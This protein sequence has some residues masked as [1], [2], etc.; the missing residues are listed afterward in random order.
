MLR[1]R[2][3][4]GVVL[5]W[6]P[7]MLVA[8][9]M[10]VVVWRALGPAD[11]A[12]AQVAEYRLAGYLGTSAGLAAGVA[13]VALL[14]GV[15]AAW[16]ISIYEFRGRSWLEWVMLLPLAVP[17]Y[18]A[19]LSYVEVLEHL[20]PAYLWIRDRLGV[21]AFRGAQRAAPWALSIVVLAATL[22]PYVFL[23]CRAA[24]GGRASGA[25]E[26]ARLLGA[27]PR[28][29]FWQVALPL[30]R[31]AL[32]AGSGLVVLET[33]NDIGVVAAFGLPTLTPGIFRI[34]GE[35]YPGTAMR[36][37]LILMGFAIFSGVFEWLLRGRRRF[38][39]ENSAAP[40]AREPA[41]RAKCA[42]IWLVC[43]G[44]LLL[45]FL[46][47]GTQLVRWA[48]LSWDVIEW[49]VFGRAA[50]HSLI[51][52]AIA[53]GAIMLGTVALVAGQRALRMP[54]LGIARRVAVLGYAAPSALVAVGVGFII[55]QLASRIP[56]AAAI[57]LSASATGLVFAA[58][59]RYLAVAVQP[60]AAGFERF[61][62][63]FHEAAR[64]TGAGPLRTLW[65]IDLPLARPA[66][67]A[68]ATLAFLDIFK[69]LPTTL[70]LR[71]FDFETLPTLIFR[72][73]DQARLPEASVPALTLVLCSLAGL[74]PLT[75]MMRHARRDR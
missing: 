68:G 22:Y 70:V 55:S 3:G 56:G 71:P 10:L 67:F 25:M 48:W 2:R 57:A 49:G 64:V 52:A 4:L 65:R 16:M 17:A 53:V 31:P 26:A 60:A 45:G 29:V 20:V 8:V 13:V 62:G 54:S 43:G 38:A 14:F 47:P 12:W 32:A 69:E 30:V 19:A 1:W 40:A 73:T 27:S 28:R 61:S 51:V 46:L 18:V 58:F 35:G 7:A 39:D 6:L 37:A 66:L 24:F 59:V 23:S 15:P 75:R 41:G 9:P 34:W 50:L 44:P 72:L 36:L 21:E 74:V 42:L 11:A 33:L 5:T 63:A